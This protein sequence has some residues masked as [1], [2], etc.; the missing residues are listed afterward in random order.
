MIGWNITVAWK[1]LSWFWSSF[2]VLITPPSFD[3]SLLEA[4]ELT[5]RGSLKVLYSLETFLTVSDKADLFN[6][7]FKVDRYWQ[8]ACSSA[9]AEFFISFF[10]KFLAITLLYR[11]LIV[12]SDLLHTIREIFDHFFPCSSTKLK[13]SISSSC[14]H[15]DLNSFIRVLFYWWVQMAKPS[16]SNSLSFSNKNTLALHKHEKTNFSPFF[17]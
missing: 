5:L 1:G 4:K 8:I 11:F 7:P 2:G 3:S 17:F 16:F 6:F 12:C 13:N 14:V 15:Y 9:I 10:F